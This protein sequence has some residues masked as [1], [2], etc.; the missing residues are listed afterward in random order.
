MGKPMSAYYFIIENLRGTYVDKHPPTPITGYQHRGRY[1]GE[2]FL[3]V[4]GTEA[5]QIRFGLCKH[6]I[7]HGANFA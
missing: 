1:D 5:R 7:D 2:N 6:F 4:M 3:D